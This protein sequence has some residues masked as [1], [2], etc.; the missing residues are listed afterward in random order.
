MFKSWEMEIR[1]IHEFI[2]TDQEMLDLYHYALG[3]RLPIII[4]GVGSPDP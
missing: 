2:K 3:I 1:F 4:R